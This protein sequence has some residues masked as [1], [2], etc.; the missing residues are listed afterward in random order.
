[1]LRELGYDL[2]QPDANGNTPEVL[3]KV[4]G[5]TELA[6]HLEN[7]FADVP[8]AQQE[9]QQMDTQINQAPQVNIPQGPGG[10][11]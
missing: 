10:P 4:A 6:A 5:H 9:L 11:G 7:N 3:A 1:M 8:T 2:T